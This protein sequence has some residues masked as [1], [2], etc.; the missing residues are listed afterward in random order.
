GEVQYFFQARINEHNKTLALISQFSLPNANLLAKSSGALIVC[1]YR[2][3][4]L[5]VVISVK[6]IISCIAM[7]PFTEPQD[8]RFFVCKKRGLDV[9]FLGGLQEYEQVAPT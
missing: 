8:G 6:N 9:A 5:L 1:Q 7:I 2:G 3:I 4:A